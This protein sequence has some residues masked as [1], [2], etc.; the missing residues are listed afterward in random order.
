MANIEGI[1]QAKNENLSLMMNPGNFQHDNTIARALPTALTETALEQ[2]IKKIVERQSAT[3]ENSRTQRRLTVSG[4]EDMKMR[5]SP[6]HA[7]LSNHTGHDYLKAVQNNQMN[8][9]QRLENQIVNDENERLQNQMKENTFG[10]GA[11]FLK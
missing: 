11:D 8:I 1:K 9:L 10:L 2:E 4:Y 5:L 6:R 3:L 7:R